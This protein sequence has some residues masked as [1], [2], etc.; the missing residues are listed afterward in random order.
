MIIQ[1]V[2]TGIT[3]RWPGFTPCISYSSPKTARSSESKVIPKYHRMWLKNKTPIWSSNSIS[4]YIPKGTESWDSKSSVHSRF[5]TIVQ[6]RKEPATHWLAGKW[7]N[8]YTVYGERKGVQIPAT[9][10][11]NHTDLMLSE[12]NQNAR[13]HFLGL[14]LYEAPSIGRYIQEGYQR[15]PG[16]GEGKMKNCWLTSPIFPFEK[17]KK[18]WT[19]AIH[20]VNAT[21]WHTQNGYNGKLYVIYILPQVFF[22]WVDFWD[23]WAWLCLG[24][25]L[26]SMLKVHFWQC[27]GNQM[28]CFW[29]N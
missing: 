7:E 18:S 22:V 11:I 5:C 9:W 20:T 10:W 3:H 26:F 25:L 17:M 23:F 21:E 14:H 8:K 15:Y 19:W 1:F 4:G 29:W 6:R 2:G 13:T 16:A 28:L 27:L 12:I 24:L